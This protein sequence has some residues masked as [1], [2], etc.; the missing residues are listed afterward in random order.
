M[1]HKLETSFKS[2]GLGDG[3]KEGGKAL[4]DEQANLRRRER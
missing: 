3:L 1:G 4:R 2:T